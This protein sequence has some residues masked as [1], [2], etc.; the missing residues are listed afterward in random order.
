MKF[1]MRCMFQYEDQYNICP[2]CGFREGTQP[3]EEKCIT[4]GG[5]L[6]DRYIVGM[7]LS[8]DPWLIRYLGWDALNEKC[9]SI[10]EYMPELYAKRSRGETRVTPEKNKPYYKALDLLKEKAQHLSMLSVP[11]NICPVRDFFEANR[12]LYVITDHCAGKTLGEY[13]KA[14]GN[15]SKDDAQKMFVPLMESLDKLHEERYVIGGFSPDDLIVDENNRLVFVSYLRSIFFNSS[16]ETAEAAHSQEY[17]YYPYERLKSRGTE[18]PEPSCDVYSAAMVFFRMIGGEIPDCRERIAIYQRSGKDKLFK[19]KT[20][21]GK[22]DENTANALRNAMFIETSLRTPDMESFIRELTGEKEVVLRSEKNKKKTPLAVKIGV[23]A[24]ALA[25]TGLILGLTVFRKGTSDSLNEGQT[26]VPDIVNCSVSDAEGEL[27]RSELL[28]EIEGKKIN[29]EIDEDII[30]AQSL[31]AGS[32]VNVNSTVSVVVNAHSGTVTMPNLLGMN[33][34]NCRDLLYGLGI[35][36]TI[37]R[38]YSS[39]IAPDCVISQSAAPYATIKTD[40]VVELIVSDGLSPDTPNADLPYEIEDLTG[41]TLDDIIPETDG[42][43]GNDLFGYSDTGNVSVRDGSDGAHPYQVEVTERV[44]DDTKPE[45]TIIGQRP[46]KGIK[47]TPK[48]KVEVVVTTARKELIVPD[49]T[50]VSKEDAESTLKLYGLGVE[51]E[52]QESNT[53]KEGYIISQSPAAGE[54]AEIDSTVKLIVSIGRE[55]VTVPELVGKDISEASKL[56]K[57]A[58]LVAEYTYTTDTTAD[59]DTVLQQSL[60]P[61]RKV[62]KGSSILVTVSTKKQVA[63]VPSVIGLTSEQAQTTLEQSGFKIDRFD[64]AKEAKSDDISAQFT[65]VAQSPQAGLYYP[66]GSSVL[67]VFGDMENMTGEVN[68]FR[69]GDES[70]SMLV[71]E[72]YVLRIYVPNKYDD[73]Y[74]TP[75]PGQSSVIDYT[76]INTAPADCYEITIIGK[77]GGTET[78][79]VRFGNTYKF[80]KFIVK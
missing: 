73:V 8:S 52:E 38:E 77:A 41:K 63:E 33:I 58:T 56:L 31:S 78:M 46:A 35:R 80:C 17:D 65:A 74:Y 11:D 34:E 32:V 47:L 21:G 20:S 6:A 24:A 30:T 9:V 3:D 71:G 68:G 54:S 15:M 5:I 23:P 45:G 62:S 76:Y 64:S 22:L 59:E 39:S 51:F 26:I 29:D 13:L 14:N 42:G 66:Q 43:T 69:L 37:G 53:V 72:K 70:I 67:T 19:L 36:Y 79:T 40:E 2:K 10:Y 61:G 28:M 48:D 57:A 49:V 50:L 75:D 16:D 12:T 18:E 27:E 60:A 25:V 44:Y 55:A 4:P 7:P 1:C